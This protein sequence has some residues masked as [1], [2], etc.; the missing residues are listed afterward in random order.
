MVSCSHVWPPS[1]GDISRMEENPAVRTH[2]WSVLLRLLKDRLLPLIVVNQIF[3]YYQLLKDWWLQFPFEKLPMFNLFDDSISSMSKSPKQKPG[4]EEPA[5]H[6]PHRCL[7][8][9]RTAATGGRQNRSN[10]PKAR[11]KMDTD[12]CTDIHKWYSNKMSISVIIHGVFIHGNSWRL[13][14]TDHEWHGCWGISGY[15]WVRME[16]SLPQ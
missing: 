8:Q 4:P 1:L 10:S 16:V 5:E 7:L 6:T 13:R 15:Q 12:G 11:S 14:N 3:D 2:D 9:R